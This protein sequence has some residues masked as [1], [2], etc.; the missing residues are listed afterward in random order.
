MQIIIYDDSDEYE[1]DKISLNN[2]DL[3]DDSD[4]LLQLIK[5]IIEEYLEA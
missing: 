2:Y 4:I 5:D 3:E 1:V